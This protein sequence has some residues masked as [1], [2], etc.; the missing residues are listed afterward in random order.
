MNVQIFVFAVALTLRLGAV[1]ALGGTGMSSDSAVY[2][3]PAI[4]IATDHGFT[5]FHHGIW[6]NQYIAE[7]G[8]TFF[9]AFWMIFGISAGKGILI[10]QSI[11]GAVLAPAIFSYV[12]RRSDRRTAAA[13]SLIYA[14]DPVAIGPCLLILRELFVMAVIFAALSAA[15]LL[16]KFSAAVKGF[17][18]GLSSLSFPVFGLWSIWLWLLDRRAQVRK[19]TLAVVV[20]A[21]SFSGV[22]IARNM[23]ISDGNFV[24]RRHLTGILLYYTANYDF[25]WLPDPAEPEFARIVEETRL[26]FYGENAAVMNQREVETA[27]TRETLRLLKENPVKVGWRFVKANFWFWAETP[28]SMGMLKSKPALRWTIEIF[29]IAQMI[30]FFIGTAFAISRS[31]GAFRFVW[32]T[33]LYLA[34]FVFPFMPIPRYYVCVVPLIDIMAAYGLMSLLK[35]S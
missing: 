33:V 15:D 34:I 27:V 9:L 3:D 30:L 13:A 6:T 12:E 11:L 21:F 28:G 22:W 23:L 24:F 17:F 8:Y 18:L 16:G 25:P 20:I 7:P 10:V 26:K 5:Y 14:V 4:A 29:H 31:N 2:L 35:K 32:G 19:I 1:L